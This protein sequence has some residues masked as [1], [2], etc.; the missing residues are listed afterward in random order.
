MTRKGSGQIDLMSFMKR[1]STQGVIRMEITIAV[2]IEE[3]EVPMQVLQKEQKN[4][5][6]LF[7]VSSIFE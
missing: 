2:V 3:V 7:D 5:N 4:E 1:R 6:N